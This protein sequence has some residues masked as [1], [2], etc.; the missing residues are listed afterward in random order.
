MK[1]FFA[2]FASVVLLT[3]CGPQGEEQSADSASTEMNENADKATTDNLNFYGDSISAD[4][5]IAVSELATI[6]EKDGGF[7]GKV[8]TVIHETCQKKGCW[9]KVDMADANDM[10]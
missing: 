8:T 10:R 5:A 6:V 4:G 2:L 1:Q 9:M 7:E 3:A